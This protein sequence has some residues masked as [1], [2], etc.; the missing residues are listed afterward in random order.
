MDLK[1]NYVFLFCKVPFVVYADFETILETIPQPS[2][3]STSTTQNIKIHKPFSFAYY[4]KC[5]FD[6]SI[7]KFVSY[8]GENCSLE[9]VKRLRND[10]IQIYDEHLSKTVPMKELSPLEEQMFLNTNRCHLCKKFLGADRHKDHDH[11]TG[12]FRG[13]AH[14]DCNVNARVPHYVPIFFHNLSGYDGHLFVKELYETKKEKDTISVLPISTE[15]YI[16]MSLKIYL[17][18]ITQER[19]RYFEL[20]F[21]DSYRFLSSSIEKLAKTLNAND[22][23]HLQHHFP[24]Q[25]IELLKRKGVFPY[26]Y[27]AS[28]DKLNECKLPTKDKF[29]NSLLMQHISDDD[30]QHAC[31]VWQ[32][33]DI[34]NLGGYSDLYL[35][36]DVFLLVDI[37][38]KFR[39]E[40][41][42]VY[43]LD[44]THYYTLASFAWSAM[45]KYT[46]VVLPL[47]T[48]VNM[49]HFIK[50]GIRGGI[51]QCS[52]RY[53][54]S[55]NKYM[56]EEYDETKDSTYNIYI[57]AN[58]LYAYAMSQYLPH[59][60]FQWINANTINIE[61][62]DEDDE[63]GYI[64][65]VD[66][67]YPSNLHNDHNDYPFCVEKIIPPNSTTKIPKLI[68]NLMNKEKYII[69][70]KNLIQ[71]LKY[72]LKLTKIH[73]AIKFRQ[74]CY[75]KSYIELNN[76]RRAN[77][78]DPF[79]QNLMKEMNN[80]IY[81]KTVE[82]PENYR[83]VK[84]CDRWDR[85]H[86]SPGMNEYVTS[87]F[88]NSNKI[89]TENL[90]MV[91]MFK[92]DI[93]Y[94]KPFY[95]GFCV[96]ELAK[97]HMY[98]F[99]YNY[100]KQKFPGGLEL[101]Y[102]DTDSFVYH[103]TCDDIYNE[104][105]ANN[106]RFDTSNYPINNQYNIPLLNKKKLGA[107]K[108]ENSGNMLIEFIGL[109]SKLY[110]MNIKDI[111]Q[112]N[113]HQIKKAKG[114]SRTAVTN[115]I[116]YYD[117]KDCLR[118]NSTKYCDIYQFRSNLHNIYTQYSKKC[119]LNAQDDKRY[120]IPNSYN[121]LAWG[122]YKIDEY[123]RPEEN[124]HGEVSSD[125]E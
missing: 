108:D 39:F 56:H 60:N 79:T 4:I 72:G 73:R 29:F 70:H 124:D 41:M 75:L 120:L 8:R 87:I 86:R 31:N 33:F 53:A 1:K 85:S 119:A 7:S 114:V 122:H 11:L 5:S 102:T 69:Y 57:D 45:L 115:Q 63:I 105:I 66:L 48:D 97:L 10:L 65:E 81:G 64:L 59:N 93:E 9:F 49:L 46:G 71:A 67:E 43:D 90:V 100:M 25:N 13:A 84:F 74:S 26:D 76:I 110:A 55:N 68:P 18:N 6:N 101:M 98:D 23:V 112:N 3:S 117:Y 30:Y 61:K 34:T 111:E 32:K 96:L 22:F 104:L 27:I 91:E 83:K 38:E 103:V 14:Y 99:H 19:F 15:K 106:E 12:L 47:L 44:P 95:V 24:E 58:N 54:K 89:L 109:R 42:G 123:R 50:K 51:S 77:S 94:N 35:K 52:K 16:S 88:F 125:D 40:C 118:N 78:T 113:E 21:L 82:N 20:R 37:F 121:T 28:L 107:F 2:T 80:I 92:S 17:E 116:T 36:T 62:L